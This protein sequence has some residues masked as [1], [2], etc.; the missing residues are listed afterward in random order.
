MPTSAILI[1]IGQSAKEEPLLRKGPVLVLRVE[2]AAL[3]KMQRIEW[4][5]GRKKRNYD[6]I[7]TSRRKFNR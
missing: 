4:S 3:V 2:I 5:A 7:Q 1:A 6:E